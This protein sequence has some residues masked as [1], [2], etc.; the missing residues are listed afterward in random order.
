MFKPRFTK[1]NEGGLGAQASVK[2]RREL[3]ATS[4]DW[5]FPNCRVPEMLRKSADS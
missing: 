5:R 2:A 4:Q 3:I 1:W